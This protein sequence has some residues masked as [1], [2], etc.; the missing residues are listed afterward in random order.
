MSYEMSRQLQ[1]ESCIN[2]ILTSSHPQYKGILTGKFFEYVTTGKPI[3]C[4]IK[5][6]RD[7]QLEHIFMKYNLGIVLYHDTLNWVDLK[8]FILEE[9]QY[10]QKFHETKHKIDMRILDDFNWNNSLEIL[11]KILENG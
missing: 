2:I 7:E 1:Q 6:V 10:F 9:W 5:G 11:V 3:V 8:N 4:I